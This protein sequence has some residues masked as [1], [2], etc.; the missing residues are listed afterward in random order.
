MFHWHHVTVRNWHSFVVA[1]TATACSMQTAQLQPQHAVRAR[2][3]VPIGATSSPTLCVSIVF[4]SMV[5][6]LLHHFLVEFGVAL[7]KSQI[8]LQDHHHAGA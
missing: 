8:G 1:A 4:F 3:S 2:Q 6:R 7:V 5:F